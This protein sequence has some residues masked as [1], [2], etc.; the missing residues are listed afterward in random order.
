M[1]V[2]KFA[3]MTK[4]F[5]S[6]DCDAHVTEPPW[7]WERAKDYLTKDE[8]EALKGSFCF[9]LKASGLSLTDLAMRAPPRSFMV[10]PGWSTSSRWQAPASTI[11]SSVP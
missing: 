10:R 3:P 7:L 2:Q 9:D 8:F 6:F 1:P 11:T 5:P 4:E